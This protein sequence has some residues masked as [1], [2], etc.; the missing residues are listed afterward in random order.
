MDHTVVVDGA[1]LQFD[2]GQARSGEVVTES[3]QK[4]SP[5]LNRSEMGNDTLN[6]VIWRALSVRFS[7]MKIRTIL[8]IV[9]QNIGEGPFNNTGMCHF[10]TTSEDCEIMLCRQLERP[11]LLS[12]LDRNKYEYR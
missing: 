6:H 11:E 2:V 4:G 3:Y 8:Y 9:Y 12:H 7:S 10:I 1:G 5:P